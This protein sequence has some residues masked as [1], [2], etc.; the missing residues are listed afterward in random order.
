[1]KIT[2]KFYRRDTSL[3]S[4][5]QARGEPGL[6]YPADVEVGSIPNKG[7]FVLYTKERQVLKVTTV[8]DPEPGEPVAVVLVE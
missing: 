7:D 6:P 5:E 2:L 3:P 1:M 8:T 4:P